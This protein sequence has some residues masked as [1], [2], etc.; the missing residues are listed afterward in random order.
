M[1]QRSADGEWRRRPL[2]VRRPIDLAAVR[3]R[4]SA[5]MVVLF[6]RRYR[7]VNPRLAPLATFLARR[8]WQDW[9]FESEA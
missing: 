8:G 5:P 7:V 3:V 2:P 9:F 6:H 1:V 4:R